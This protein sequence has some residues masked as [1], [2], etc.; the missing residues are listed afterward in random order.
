MLVTAIAAIVGDLSVESNIELAAKEH[1]RVCE[2]AVVDNRGAGSDRHVCHSGGGGELNLDGGRFQSAGAGED[3]R[4]DGAGLGD[5][6]GES[7]MSVGDGIGK[8]RSGRALPL[9][10][11]ARV[12]TSCMATWIQE[13]KSSKRP[14]RTS[15]CFGFG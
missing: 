8:C 5:G 12:A 2:D 7:G 15:C 14:R 10:A 13:C 3:F 1:T 11:K 4:S 6:G 9:Q